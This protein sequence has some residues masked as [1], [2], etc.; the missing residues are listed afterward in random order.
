VDGPLA[1]AGQCSRG[2]PVKRINPGRARV[3]G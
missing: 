2:A 1:F 3:C